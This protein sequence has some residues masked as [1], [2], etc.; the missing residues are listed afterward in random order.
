MKQYIFINVYLHSLGFIPAGTIIYDNTSYQMGFSYHKDYIDNNYPPINPATLNWRREKTAN[1]LFSNQENFDKTFLELLPSTSDWSYSVLLSKYPEY[2]Q[3][4]LV[5][6]LFFLES[7]TVG[8]LQSH[9]E[10]EED[11]KSII[12]TDWLEKI[13]NSSID[14][15]SK[16]IPHIPYDHCFIPLTTYGGVRPKCL[17]KDNDDNL[18]IA[19]FNIPDDELNF[20]K[21]EHL[22][23]NMAKDLDLPIA[24]SD[25]L[26]FEN[27]DIF[28]SYRFDRQGD[29]RQHSLP[30][31]ALSDNLNISSTS[32]EYSGKS[33]LILKEI[34]NYSD[35]QNK[36]TLLLIQKF[37]LDV[38]INNTDNHLKNIRLILNNN[39]LWEVAPLYDITMTPYITEFIYNPCAL[40]TSKLYLN[41]PELSQHMAQLFNVDEKYIK[42]MIQ[43]TINV[44]SNYQSYCD[45]YNISDN[46]REIISKSINIG[47]DKNNEP[48]YK[49]NI[50][51]KS[52]PKPKPKNI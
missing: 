14:F 9:L 24:H 2:E 37:L 38:A 10:K 39:N 12:G 7:R 32:S 44:V 31:F 6:K 50:V 46:D 20:A 13:Y 43:K 40:K 29:I 48:L 51:L 33:P 15:Y 23:M 5:Q 18:W 42:E 27:N 26:N 19:K 34:L 52:F 1:F 17:Y 47:L 45:K 28:L 36:D 49:N 41:N 4:T 25:I 8:G 11:E 3:M 30:F 21:M 35:F 22:C 16:N